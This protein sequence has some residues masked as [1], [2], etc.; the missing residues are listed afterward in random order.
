MIFP[1]FSRAR[2]GAIAAGA[3]ALIA[4]VV[5]LCIWPQW[6]NTRF[7][8]ADEWLRDTFIRWHASDAHEQRILVVDIDESSL[9]TQPWPWPRAKIAD[10]IELLLADGAHGV[11]LDILQE[12]PADSAGDARMAALAANAPVVLAQMFDFLPTLPPLR[13]GILVGGLPATAAPD[14]PQ[15]Y[16]YLGNNAGLA[17]ARYAGNIGIVP[18]PDGVLRR[19]APYTAFEGRRYP[20]LSLAL[21]KCCAGAAIEPSGRSMRIPYSRDWAAYDVVKASTLLEGKIPEGMATGKLALIGSSSLSIGDRIATPLGAST[22][23]LLVHASMLGSLLDAAAGKA[24]APWPGQWIGTAWTLLMA[25]LS[26]WSLPR[27]S[28]AANA[29]LLAAVSLA[30]LGLAAWMA[31]HDAYFSPAAPLLATLVLLAVGVPLQWQLSQHRSRRLLGTLKQYV[32]REVVDELLRCGLRDPLAP[33]LLEVTTLVADM[34]GYTSQVESLSLEEASRLTT[35]FLDCL[36]RPVLARHGTLDKYTGDGLVAFWGAP[37]PN[38]EHADLA[39]E[40]AGDILREVARFSATRA[41]QGLAPLRVRIGIES[42][43]AMAGDYGTSMRSIYT[44]VGDSVNTAARLEQAARDYPHDVIVGEGT[45]RLARR[46]RLAPLGERQL[47][48]K[49]KPIR[50]YTLAAPRGPA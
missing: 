19:L 29:A 20:A 21:L 8:A 26:A 4:A 25:A 44:A 37:L 9:A 6:G 13:S 45:A 22:A 35:D 24:P 3:Q 28:A 39:L 50:V 18:D 31:P 46:H 30:W 10:L 1:A 47:R 34:E 23:G 41:Q 7:V 17:Q 40:A 36:T 16:G 32:A 48:G 33:R 2:P 15:A 49:E 12:K 42:G 14:A 5:L 38:A 27:L 11:A 43:A